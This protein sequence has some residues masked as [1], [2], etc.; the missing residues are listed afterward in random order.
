MSRQ[1][2]SRLLVHAG[3]TGWG[4]TR[5]YDQ[6]VRLFTPVSSEDASLLERGVTLTGPLYWV[7]RLVLE[8]ADEDAIWVVLA[9]PDEEV[10]A[11]E[12]SGSPLLGYREFELP[13]ELPARFPVNRVADD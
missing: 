6:F 13:P 4:C 5:N 2:G 11:F 12:Q 1:S 3:C 10:A 8:E 7:D 9:V